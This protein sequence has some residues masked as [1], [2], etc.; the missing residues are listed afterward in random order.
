MCTADG[1]GKLVRYADESMAA[2]KL[3]IDLNHRAAQQLLKK[4]KGIATAGLTP[5]LENTGTDIHIGGNEMTMKDAYD[6]ASAVQTVTKICKGESKG[7]AGE[8]CEMAI[9]DTGKKDK[10]ERG[11]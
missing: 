7:E 10:D 6:K 5:G 4:A 11:R 8:R 2:S 1:D 9:D 3:V